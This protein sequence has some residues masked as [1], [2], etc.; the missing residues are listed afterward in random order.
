MN[1]VTL[2][3]SVLVHLTELVFWF[4]KRPSFVYMDTVE[5]II[6]NI[7]NIITMDNSDIKIVDINIT[8]TGQVL[9]DFV[10]NDKFYKKVEVVSE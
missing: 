3:P 2:H 8:Q 6:G 4:N 1:N 7:K 9:V 5:S 10:K